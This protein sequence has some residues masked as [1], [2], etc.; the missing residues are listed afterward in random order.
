MKFNPETALDCY[1]IDHRRQYAPGVELVFSNLTPR[2]TYRANPPPNG[3]V[4][5]GLQYF[6]KE[7]LINKWNED[8]FNKPKDE[9]L[10]RFAR[11][12]NNYLGPNQVGTDH[13]EALHDLGYLP[14]T[15]MSLPE[16]SQVPYKVPVFVF[17][18]TDPKFY[19]LTNYLETIASVTIWP[20]T[21]TA[22]TAKQFKDILTKF[23]DETSDSNDFVKFSGHNFSYRGCFG[24][25][26]ACLA[27]AG[28]LTSF[29]GSDTLPGADF[30]EEYYNANSD[31]ELVSCSVNATEHSV[32]ASYGKE[33][34]LE[35]F[36]RLI[37]DVY[38]TGILSIVSDTFDYWQVITDFTVK[39]K[40]KILNRDGKTVFR[41]D[42]GD[43]VKIIT[44]YTW[45]EV[46]DI[47]DN[48]EQLVCG[49]EVVKYNGEYYHVICPRVDLVCV[50]NKLTEAE[51]K[52]TVECLWDIFGGTTNN[53]GFKEINPKVG[54]ILGDGVTFNV[55]TAICQRLKDKGFAS[56]NLVYGVGSYSIQYGV[57]RDSD[58]FAVKSTYCEVN[59]QPREI[60]KDPKTD[61]SN[62]KKSA[63][64][65]TAV[66][67]DDSGKFILKDQ[68][69]WDDVL[70]CELVKVF[71]NGKILKEYSLAE[72]RGQLG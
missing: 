6:I 5:F 13:I 60:F 30:V 29:V 51:V 40:D 39:L 49:K 72:I 47:S 37:E 41:P 10:K 34:E 1:K 57:S 64:G 24:H 32:M 43:N 55:M 54:A 70:D 17:W 35:A 26:A 8:F 2:K 48:S 33:D 11:R 69:T 45:T 50:G 22:T 65:L 42:S 46:T 61:T 63:K 44:G 68:A 20:L 19:W 23:A 21:T 27:D 67:K 9:I 56:T 58:G 12:I 71:E 16:G 38:P 62:M 25:E 7:Y 14:I 4:W 31:N 15:I 52:G 53:K 66:F 3:I 59:G 28:W 36:R 18:N